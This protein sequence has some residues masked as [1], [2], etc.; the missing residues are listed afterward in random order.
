[1]KLAQ[2]SKF[3]PQKWSLNTKIYEFLKK[4]IGSPKNGNIRVFSPNVASRRYALLEKRATEKV[5]SFVTFLRLMASLTL[6]N[7]WYVV[8]PG[9]LPQPTAHKN[10]PRTTC[11]FILIA[12]AN[13]FW[14]TTTLTGV[15]SFWI[16]INPQKL[17]LC[18]QPLDQDWNNV[19]SSKQR[20]QTQA[21][22]PEQCG[23]QQ[24]KV[25]TKRKRTKKATTLE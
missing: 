20:H 13:L 15:Y 19:N 3:T 25:N 1:M 24:M 18:F 11:V 14:S 8:W 9:G 6:A 7:M 21:T 2:K 16:E 4:R 12:T 22:E 5:R 10:R 23:F 17:I